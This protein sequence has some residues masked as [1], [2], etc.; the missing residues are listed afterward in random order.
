M[1]ANTGAPSINE[2]DAANQGGDWQE[3]I[4]EDE[5]ENWQQATFNE[6]NEWGVGT[7]VDMDQNWQ[8]NSVNS[9]PQETSRTDGEAGHPQR[10]REVWHESP[11]ANWS[12]GQTSNHPRIRRSAP[13]RRPNRFHPPDDDN[14]YSMEL[15]E[16]LSRYYAYMSSV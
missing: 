8:G 7:S 15:R 10:T 4:I 9:W 16:L 14:V 13:F 6:L 3:Q 5:R 12:R 11:A 1:E 2:Q